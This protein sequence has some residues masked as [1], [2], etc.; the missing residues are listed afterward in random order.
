MADDDDDDGA[1]PVDSRVRKWTNPSG[2]EILTPAERAQFGIDEQIARRRASLAAAGIALPEQPATN[3][4]FHVEAEAAH[5]ANFAISTGAQSA[6][7]RFVE[8]L[9][10]KFPNYDPSWSPEQQATWF[11][12]F[13]RLL[14][15]GAVP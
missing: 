6:S 8:L 3:G 1:P 13:N 5:A 9:V 12:A 14:A 7:S 10:A 2:T 15:M 11:A 4:A